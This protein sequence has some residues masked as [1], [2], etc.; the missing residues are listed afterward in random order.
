MKKIILSSLL[1]CSFAL[2][3]TAQVYEKDYLFANMLI[4]QTGD[5]DFSLYVNIKNPSKYK[6]YTWTRNIKGLGTSWTTAVCDPFL[7]H[8]DDVNTAKFFMDSGETALMTNHFYMKDTAGG[9]QEGIVDIIIEND[10]TNAKDTATFKITVWNRRLSIERIGQEVL[11]VYPNPS[12]DQI[13]ITS[14]E[15]I[16]LIEIVDLNGKVLQ[17]RNISEG[18]RTAEVKTQ[19]IP[20]GLY[21]VRVRTNTGQVTTKKITVNK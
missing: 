5:Q 17:T 20:T 16:E 13:N 9:G 15:A 14:S 12:A 4:E 7:C 10:S 6:N 1:I 11:N 3:G 19:F 8:G 18:L 21:L 2:F